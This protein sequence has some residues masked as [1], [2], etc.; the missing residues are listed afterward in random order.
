M[1][2]MDIQISLNDIEKEQ[3]IEEFNEMMA[4]HDMNEGQLAKSNLDQTWSLFE[5]LK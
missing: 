1:T 3:A 4:S 5:G 2:D